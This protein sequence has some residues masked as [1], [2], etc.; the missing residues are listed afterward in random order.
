M[1]V[2]HAQD[3]SIL[4]RLA[5]ASDANSVGAILRDIS[6]QHRPIKTG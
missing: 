2:R 3:D 1:A 5:D 6:D 4:P